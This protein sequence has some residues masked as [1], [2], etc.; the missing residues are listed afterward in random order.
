MK[1]CGT[2]FSQRPPLQTRLSNPN[3]TV[4]PSIPLKSP[5]QPKPSYIC[6]PTVSLSR[7]VLEQRKKA[8]EEEELWKEKQKQRDKKLQ[9][10][11]L[12][13]AEANDP[14]LALSQT[15]LTKLREFRYQ[16]GDRV[17]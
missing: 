10:V 3:S 7:K 9:R 16:R 8:D 11:V 2:P 6:D 5:S 4:C 17:S 14:H 15:H 1:S 13:R 12:K